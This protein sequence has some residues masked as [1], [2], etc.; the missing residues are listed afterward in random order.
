MFVG[1]GLGDS[2]SDE[3]FPGGLAAFATG[4]PG[5]AYCMMYSSK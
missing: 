2:T 5:E 4:N 3:S 1:W